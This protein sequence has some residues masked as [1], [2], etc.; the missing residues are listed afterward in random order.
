MA[1]GVS[2]AIPGEDDARGK[3]WFFVPYSVYF[4]YDV[5][6]TAL[7]LYSSIWIV[8][9]SHYYGHFDFSATF[10]RLPIG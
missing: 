1:Y 4:V 7:G 6:P 8:G 3:R 10:V 2:Y 5:R 9:I